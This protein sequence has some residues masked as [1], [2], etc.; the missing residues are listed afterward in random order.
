MRRNRWSVALVA[1]TIVSLF[2][3]A[4]VAP[5]PEVVEV[6][7]EVMVEVTKIVEKEGETVVEQVVVTATPEPAPTEE[8]VQMI[9]PDFKNPDTYVV[10]TGAGWPETMDPAWAY[11]T[12]SSGVQNNIYEGVIW[13]NRD[14]T[15][16][17]VP[18]LAT[19]WEVNEL[20]LIHI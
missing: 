12:A 2:L 20:S 17:F 11:D 19:D 7:K 6:E 18:V 13:F 15:D 16:E 10:V 1:V 14:R 3:G 9:S 5:T 8:P 4:C